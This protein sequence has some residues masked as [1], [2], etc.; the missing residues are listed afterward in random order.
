[1]GG[2]TVG[3]RNGC[4]VIRS[5][6]GSGGRKPFLDP[7]TDF[8]PRVEIWTS[9]RS[10]RQRD[11]HGTTRLEPVV[12]TNHSRQAFKMWSP[13]GSGEKGGSVTSVPGRLDRSLRGS[14]SD[15]AAVALTQPRS[16]CRNPELGRVRD[17]APRSSRGFLFDR[18]SAPV[19]DTRLH[20]AARSGSN[21]A[22]GLVSWPSE[23]SR[24]LRQQPGVDG[25]FQRTKRRKFGIECLEKRRLLAVVSTPW[26]TSAEFDQ[27]TGGAPAVF[28]FGVEDGPGGGRTAPEF[29]GFSFDKRI[30]AGGIVGG[31]CTDLGIFGDLC[32]P[33]VGAKGFVEAE[34]RLGLE[35]GFYV[36]AGTGSLL[37]DGTFEYDVLPA[38]GGGF[39]IITD[40]SLREGSIRTISP[41]LS[42]FVDLVFEVEGSA[43]GE[44]CFIA[45][46]DG[47][48][49]FSES[50]RIP[51]IGINR[52]VR[53]SAGVPILRNGVP[54]FD[55]NIA[56]LNEGLLGAASD[57]FERLNE[58]RSTAESAREKV[59]EFQKRRDA[60][61][62]SQARAEAQQE[63]DLA[64]SDER[65]ARQRENDFN[66]D[67]N[68]AGRKFGGGQL[69]QVAFGQAST[70]LLGVEAEITA[71]VGVGGVLN[72]SQDLGSIALTLPE[73][74]L[75]ATTRNIETPLVA[76]TQDSTF[77]EAKRSL[78][79]LNVN[80]GGILGGPI[81]LGTKK[82]EAGPFS[83]SVTTFDYIIDA[84][85]GVRQ[86]IEAQ[87][88]G[89][90]VELDFRNRDTDSPVRVNA[91]VDGVA[92][93]N[94]TNLRF[95]VGA[96]VTVVPVQGVDVD[97]VPRLDHE[98]SVRNDIGL[99]IDVDGVLEALRASLGAFGEE[100]SIGPLLR[101]THDLFSADL[102]SIFDNR[103]TIDPPVVEF[104]AFALEATPIAD[105][106]LSIDAPASIDAVDPIPFRITVTN[107]GPSV[108]ENVTFTVGSGSA[109]F[110]PIGSDLDCSA[111]SDGGA[112]CG[113]GTLAAGVSRDYRLLFEAN[114]DVDLAGINARVEASTDL[115]N[116]IFSPK[117]DFQFVSI[118]QPERIIVNTAEDL[119]SCTDTACS[120]RGALAI[121]DASPGTDLVIIEAGINPV[122]SLG[123]IRVI[124]DVRIIGAGMDETMVTAG[125]DQ[126]HFEFVGVGARTYELVGLTLAGGRAPA[127]DFLTFEDRGGS[128]RIEDFAE[129]DDSLILRKTRFSDNRTDGTGGAIFAAG[130]RIRVEESEFVGNG[131]AQG[132]AIQASRDA[133]LEI[134]ETE[135]IANTAT[136]RGGAIEFSAAGL[137]IITSD[138]R[139]NSAGLDGGAIHYSG[140]FF[141][142]TSS[143]TVFT[144]NTA[145][146][147]G[148]AVFVD[149]SNAVLAES[150][151]RGNEASQSGGALAAQAENRFG[152]VEDFFVA[153]VNNTFVGN[154]SPE[155]AAVAL[156]EDGGQIRFELDRTAF[157]DQFGDNVRVG[158]AAVDSRGFN[159]SDDFSITL[160]DMNDRTGTEPITLDAFSIFGGTPVV[161]TSTPGATVGLLSWN[162]PVLNPERLMSMEFSVDDPRFEV[163]GSR[164]KVRDDQMLAG[165]GLFPIDVSVVDV[166][167]RRLTQ[168]IALSAVRPTPPVDEVRVTSLPRRRIEV[169]Y[170][171][172]SSAQGYEVAVKQVGGPVLFQSRVQGREEV[173][174]VVDDV[175][176]MTEIEVTVAAFNFTGISTP[177][178][179]TLTTPED[180]PDLVG[181]VQVVATSPSDLVVSFDAVARAKG[182]RIVELIEGIPEVVVEE[183]PENVTSAII[184]GAEPDTTRRFRVEAFNESGTSSSSIV[185][186]T[187][188]G[189]LPTP[190]LGFDVTPSAGGEL[191]L[192]WDDSDNETEYLVVGRVA[193][194]QT[195]QVLAS[196]PANQTD[197][198]ISGLEPDTEALV[199][200]AAVSSEGMARSPFRSGRVGPGGLSRIGVL[201]E[202]LRLTLDDFPSAIPETLSQLDVSGIGDNTF[203]LSVAAVAT[204]TGGRLPLKHDSGDTI[205]YGDG[206]SVEPPEISSEGLRHRLSAG[207]TR[208]EI[209]NERSRQNPLVGEDV[210]RDGRID[211]SDALAIINRIRRD[212]QGP[213]TIPDA[214]D[215]T[216]EDLTGPFYV[217]VDGDN[218][219]G[220]ADALNV[221]NAIRRARLAEGE[222]TSLPKSSQNDSARMIADIERDADLVAG[223]SNDADRRNED[224]ASPIDTR[225]G[226]P[227]WAA[228][229][230]PGS[231][232]LDARQSPPERHFLDEAGDEAA[233][234]KLFQ[235]QSVFANWPTGWE[236][237]MD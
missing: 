191:S 224:I 8:E 74:N 168:T 2:R 231:H 177:V 214:T 216:A 189:I 37:H 28:G 85:L 174:V 6:R 95:P 195:D 203:E 88:V 237:F 196:V 148:G 57:A 198:T 200:V 46:V 156:I 60:A 27:F 49:D 166:L 139:Q 141:F 235:S 145:G 181:D 63:V 211:V 31:S 147:H 58:A 89:E 71:G 228:L 98:F 39:Q 153:T 140:T 132:G 164:L 131:A 157:I 101:R 152:N 104:P 184:V 5:V 11:P 129:R 210:N 84:S 233:A 80:L 65:A 67:S 73:V 87:T 186:G 207:A 61:R 111:T 170:D 232:S 30:T 106:I 62:D 10:R 175:P 208:V 70:G 51:L 105:V 59:R 133:N 7:V 212:G 146:R 102:G 130:T 82:I 15:I 91:T 197:V 1:M 90:F 213:I 122:L 45:C 127:G 113:V 125:N 77:P 76:S 117:S 75:A 18:P 188:R 29:L 126:R 218:R 159:L 50:E 220:L 161:P 94:V 169:Q 143:L 86:R 144:D 172:N 47:S 99:D 56:I 128:I 114:P 55:G 52:Q 173:R 26:V 230:G 107:R 227:P 34:G 3:H 108:A 219:L 187:T 206:W 110:Q 16:E 42:A 137:S 33:K 83:G 234:K 123:Q 121:A 78:A 12:S 120:L 21:P 183:L 154:T 69:I 205:L 103:Y 163:V 192:S 124:D 236:G 119:A 118:R 194:Q 100:V 44:A 92:R 182:Y 72:A 185:E 14:S 136:G 134:S 179:V 229:C 204:A 112:V 221:I 162:L 38:S 160:D 41:T 201:D 25:V 167:G 24:F 97:V 193:G 199:Y 48:V 116:S 138:F 176:A 190:L 165:E 20:G 64:Q 109:T 23:R 93:N 17:E 222:S 96:A 180:V 142:V 202:A 32:T 226:D 225:D 68:P 158:S 215:P 53:T 155:G 150:D 36:N 43:G 66:R 209:D 171:R 40:T 81:G 9:T 135:F 22:E 223:S 151:F 54:E 178:S 13:R 4:W 149:G 19:A 35:Y 217:D 115:V 79:N